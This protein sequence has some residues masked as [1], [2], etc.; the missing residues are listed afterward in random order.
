MLAMVIFHGGVGDNVNL[1]S[2]TG[3]EK[4]H[5]ILEHWN[6]T[7]SLMPNAMVLVSN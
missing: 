6:S 1:A 7:S 4:T 2:V 5:A 3:E